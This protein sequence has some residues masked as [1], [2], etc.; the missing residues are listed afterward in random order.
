VAASVETPSRSA[1]APDERRIADRI[2]RRELHEPPRIGG[3]RVDPAPEGLLDAAGGVN[4]AGE[5]E[6]ARE[7]CRSHISKQL[8]HRERDAA[9]L[10]DDLLADAR[11]QGCSQDRVQ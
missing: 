3:K 9:R 2:G 6:A 5:P 4:A 11:V 8:Q 10:A 7:L 1:A